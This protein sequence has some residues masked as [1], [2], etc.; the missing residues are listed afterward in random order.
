MCTESDDGE[1]GVQHVDQ[2]RV[3]QNDDAA[4]G[5]VPTRQPEDRAG[6]GA[7]RV[8]CDRL[9]MLLLGVCR[10]GRGNAGPQARGDTK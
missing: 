3:A 5:D 7:T 10:G 9:V 2:R 6:A 4:I 8:V 1:L